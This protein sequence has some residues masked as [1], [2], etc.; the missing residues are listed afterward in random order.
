MFRTLIIF[1][2]LNLQSPAFSSLKEK[3]IYKMSLVNNFSFNFIQEIDQKKESGKCIIDYPKKIFCQYN[4][5]NKKI[6]ISNGRSLVIKN[7]N[8]DNYYIYPLKKTPLELLLDKK[9]IISKIRT[10]EPRDIDNKYLN[11][12][13]IDNNNELNI[14]FDKKTLNLIGWQTEDIY[15]NL[16]ITFISSVQ[17]NQKID[18]N[19][20]ILPK[21]K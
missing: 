6:I 13:I 5:I 1:F 3:I 2:L 20:F 15:Q 12:K 10:L 8:S 16:I 21:N 9:Y 4:S 7:K 18:N 17:I 11:F 19:I 14:F